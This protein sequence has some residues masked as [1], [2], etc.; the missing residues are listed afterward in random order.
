V[1]GE[2]GGGGALVKRK[3]YQWASTAFNC[4]FKHTTEITA[5]QDNQPVS[6][7]ISLID[8]GCYFHFILTFLYILI[9]EIARV[10]RFQLQAIDIHKS[11]RLSKNSLS[12]VTFATFFF[13]RREAKLIFLGNFVHIRTAFCMLAS[14][15]STEMIMHFCEH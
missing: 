3:V 8:L 14:C 7:S 10:R 2:G 6:H 4:K 13:F 1:D 12:H 11:K 9:S 15:S 5:L